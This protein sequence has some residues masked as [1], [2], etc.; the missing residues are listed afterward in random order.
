LLTSKY[1]SHRKVT[2]TDVGENF[3]SANSGLLIF[4]TEFTKMGY[5]SFKEILKVFMRWKVSGFNGTGGIRSQR[6]SE[7]L[8]LYNQVYDL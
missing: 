5:G 2:E 4:K 6:I 3:T 1:T 8:K 7:V